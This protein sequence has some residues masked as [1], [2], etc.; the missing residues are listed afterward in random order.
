VSID[1][2]KSAKAV[3]LFRVDD[4]HSVVGRN[5][6]NVGLRGKEQERRESIVKMYL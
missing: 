1:I 5:W 3:I 2:F 4:L 6:E